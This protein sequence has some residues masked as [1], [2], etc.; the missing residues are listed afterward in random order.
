MDAGAVQGVPVDPEAALRWLIRGH[1]VTLSLRATVELGLVDHLDPPATLAHLAGATQADAHAL[2]RLLALLADLGLVT[3]DAHGVYALTETGELLRRDHPGHLAALVLMQTEMA[4][5]ASWQRLSEAIRTGEGVFETVNGQTN[6]AYL[7]ANPSLEAAFNAAMARRAPMQVAA[8]RSGCDLTGISTIVDVGGGKG[9]M[10]AALLTEEPQLTGVVADRP[11]VAAAAT[12]Y[13][14]AAGLADRAHA[15]PADFFAAVPA[16]GDAYV[17]GNVI[18][19][20]NDDDSVAILRTV[21]SAM[22]PEAR[23]WLV[24]VVLDAPDRTPDATRDLHLVDLHMLVMFGARER[25]KGEYDA[26]LV[27]AGFEPGRLLVT[28]STWD[29]IESRPVAG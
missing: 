4:P 9:G 20:W 13:L 22:R 17:L 28:D 6:W 25:T 10:L 5:L 1:W 16:G 3:V 7:S 19:D 21:R 18:H 26:L 11:D 24:E 2:G 15:A 8:I 14:A 29:V 12:E 23:L 27:A